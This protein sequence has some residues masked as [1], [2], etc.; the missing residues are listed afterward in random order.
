MHRGSWR[1]F[2]QQTASKVY[3]AAHEVN[4]LYDTVGH[5]E[6]YLEIK[7]QLS[8][9]TPSNDTQHFWQLF[10]QSQ[11]QPAVWFPGSLQHMMCC[12]E[13]LFS[14]LDGESLSSV[15]SLVEEK[16]SILVPLLFYC[17]SPL[18]NPSM[19]AL[20]MHVLKRLSQSQKC[21][22]LFFPLCQALS[23]YQ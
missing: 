23:S 6:K 21:P 8:W 22:L 2:Q 16:P 17:F 9:I 18:S 10:L 20:W 15:I 3:S 5:Q 1:V 4:S 7:E 12:F 19:P 13:D 11:P 14:F